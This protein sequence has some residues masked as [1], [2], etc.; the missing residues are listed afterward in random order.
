MIKRL[1]LLVFFATGLLT[2]GLA[3][4]SGATIE[5]RDLVVSDATGK[6]PNAQL[7]RLAEQAQAM[8]ERILSFW[9]ADPGTDRLGKI[10]V[11]FDVPRR[12][13][14]SCVFY[15]DKEG[16]KRVRVVQV[17][18]TQGTPQMMAHKLTSAVFP[19]K[20]KLIRNI[21]GILS[22]AN[23]GN[24]AT[25]PMCGVSSDDWVLAL[26]QKGSYIPLNELGP[27]HESWGMKDNGGGRLSILDKARQHTAYA[28]AG[29]FGAYLLQTHGVSRI[30]QLQRQSQDRNRPF[31][32]VFGLG[33]QE[34]EASWL[35]TLKAKGPAREESVSALVKL[36]ERDPDTAC[37]AVQKASVREP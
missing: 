22:E 37:V 4:A 5:T 24:P 29:S 36:L 14:Y 30:K 6:L 15:W 1:I 23:V 21:M 2:A 33:L 17:F 3:R 10:R 8:M 35:T 18:G 16:G 12:D 20:D 11:V 19:Q 28:E 32:D 26:L 34:L 9:S 13:V 25:F 7:K 31:Q 27:D